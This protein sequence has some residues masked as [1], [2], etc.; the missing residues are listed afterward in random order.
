MRYLVWIAPSSPCVPP[1]MPAVNSS[2]LAVCRFA[3]PEMQAVQVRHVQDDAVLAA[4]LAIEVSGRRVGGAD[5]A[6]AGVAD[7]RSIQVVGSSSCLQRPP[8]GGSR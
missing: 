1:P 2:Y 5:A 8:D 7:L 6:V 3:V 4:Q